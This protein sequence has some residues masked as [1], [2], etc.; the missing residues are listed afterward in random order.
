MT[1]YSLGDE[2]RRDW[3]R[4]IKSEHIGPATFRTLLNRFGSAPEAL[5]ALPQ[6]SRQGGM[7]RPITIYARDAAESDLERADA[8][9]ARF[10]APG[11]TGYPPLLRHI[12]GAPPLL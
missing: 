12:D 2:E 1:A 10:I 8:F 5:A 3:L 7:S 9:G 4:L 6:L 11:E